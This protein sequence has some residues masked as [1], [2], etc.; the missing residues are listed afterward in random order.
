MFS[1]QTKVLQYKNNYL[2][3][4]EAT[5]SF[6]YHCHTIM[7][8]SSSSIFDV[9]SLFAL[10][11]VV[12]GKN[13]CVFPIN[14]VHAYQHKLPGKLPPQL[15]DTPLTTW[16][17]N[18]YL[19]IRLYTLLITGVISILI[20]ISPWSTKSSQDSLDLEQSTHDGVISF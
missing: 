18:I 4:W 17:P 5:V 9:F 6:H 15:T 12:H 19:T 2:N 1:V 20:S 8:V 16:F 13:I 11:K 10:A 7:N 14:Y 3:Q